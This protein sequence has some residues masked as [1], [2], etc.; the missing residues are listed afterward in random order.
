MSQPWEKYY[1]DEAKNFQFSDMSTQRI[2]D[3]LDESAATYGSRPALTTIQPT[4]AAT[5]I[6]YAEL[7]EHAEAFAGY[8]REV[9]GLKAGDTVASMTPNCIGLGWRVGGLPRRKV[10]VIIDLF[11][12]KVD[13][14]V[15][16][17]DVEKVIAL[18]IVDFFPSLKKMLLTAVLKYIRKVIPEFQTSHI[19]FAQ[20]RAEGKAALKCKDVAAYTADVTPEDTALYQYTSG[21]T[22]KSKG[23]ELSHMGSWPIAIGRIR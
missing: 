5:T 1:S 12:D 4:G 13:G 10:L 14:V 3:Y 22:G 6:T 23:A 15:C 8:L 11:G 18:S 19:P 9:A 17:T 21:T 20:A 7:K 16:A 2:S